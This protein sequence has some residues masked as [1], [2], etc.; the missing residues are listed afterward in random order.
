MSDEVYRGVNKYVN[1]L[2]QEVHLQRTRTYDTP[3]VAKG[4][5]TYRRALK[6]NFRSVHTDTWELFE[7]VETWVEK[8]PIEWE[9]L[10]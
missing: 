9:R 6:K 10:P 2:T 7:F 5:A 8:A 1:P 4:Q 3:G